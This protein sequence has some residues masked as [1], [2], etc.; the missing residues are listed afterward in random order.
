[1]DCHVL[2]IAAM[3]RAEIGADD[4]VSDDP[5]IRFVSGKS[6][7]VT[8]VIGLL[9]SGQPIRI[10][11]LVHHPTSEGFKDAHHHRASGSRRGPHGDGQQ[12]GC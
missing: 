4:I 9:G 3:A 1:M 7:C 11:G 2:L 5:P 8:R 12:R 6:R 10:K